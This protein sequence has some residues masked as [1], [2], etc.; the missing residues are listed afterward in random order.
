MLGRKVLASA[1]AIA[2]LGAMFAIS[3]PAIA[4]PLGTVT[5]LPSATVAGVSDVTTG[6]DGNVWFANNGSA[7]PTV[8]RVTPLGAITLFDVPSRPTHVTAGPD[9]NIWYTAPAGS[10]E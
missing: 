3:Q 5:V 2:S 8:G 9:G 7:R 6:A 10:G 1:I 4:A